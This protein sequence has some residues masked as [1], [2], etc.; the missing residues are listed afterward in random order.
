MLCFTS[1]FMFQSTDTSLKHN[2]SCNEVVIYR[3]KHI[4]L[5]P[6]PYAT[7]FAT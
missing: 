2:I 4:I 5:L 1:Y 7:L 3:M 6:G